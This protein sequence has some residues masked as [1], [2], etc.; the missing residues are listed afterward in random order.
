LPDIDHVSSDAHEEVDEIKDEVVVDCCG[1]INGLDPPLVL[2]VWFALA[3]NK[4]NCVGVSE[5][6]VHS[7]LCIAHR[8]L[9]SVQFVVCS[10]QCA[11]CSVQ[12]AVCIVYCAVCIVSCVLCLV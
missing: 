10:V 8:L 9:C 1:E 7:V 3:V 5:V 6:S 2:L 11:V 12:C 4:H